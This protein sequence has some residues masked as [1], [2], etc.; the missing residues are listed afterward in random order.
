VRAATFSGRTACRPRDC[1]TALGTAG[2]ARRPDIVAP[3]SALRAR[4]RHGPPGT[5]ALA[6]P[7]EAGQLTRSADTKVLLA[8]EV[9]VTVDLTAGVAFVQDGDQPALR[10]GRRGGHRRGGGP[11]LSVG[12]GRHR[13]FHGSLRPR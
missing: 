10:P 4:P 5:R 11:D 6:S 1:S 12:R 2:P 7:G 9:F 8:L 3:A 13:R